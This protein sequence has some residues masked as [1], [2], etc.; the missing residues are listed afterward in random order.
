MVIQTLIQ[1]P[2]FKFVFNFKF[3]QETYREGDNCGCGAT[4]YPEKWVPQSK[5]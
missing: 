1:L 5:N 4:G 3:Q 2:R